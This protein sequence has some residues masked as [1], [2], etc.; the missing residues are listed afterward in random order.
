M[1]RSVGLLQHVQFKVLVAD[2]DVANSVVAKRLACGGC[3]GD[4]DSGGG[5]GDSD[6]GCRSD[7]DGEKYAGVE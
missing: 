3:S 1:L 6:G 7:K 4:S 5:G 2:L